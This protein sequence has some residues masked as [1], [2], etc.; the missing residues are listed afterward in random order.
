FGWLDLR[1]FGRKT[2]TRIHRGRSR[3]DWRQS[4]YF[5]RYKQ[6]SE[7]RLECAADD[8]RGCDSNTRV[9]TEKSMGVGAEVNVV[10]L[11]LW[12]LG[13]VTAACCAE[14]F[15]VIGL[16]FDA[17]VVAQLR[18]GKAPLFEPGL[19]ALIQ[20]GLKSGRLS[21][22]TETRDALQNADILWVC[23]DTPVDEND[24]PDIVSVLVKIDRCL[25]GL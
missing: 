6:D 15:N 23:F 3:M 13:C 9:A 24:V 20:H 17:E 5:S 12:H 14:Q 11:G 25:P 1:F 4:V 22:T 21:F 10:V 18:D 7:N 2:A 19:D 16:D 8:S